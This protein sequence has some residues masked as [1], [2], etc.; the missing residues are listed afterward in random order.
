M[1]YS[2]LFSLLSFEIPHHHLT[3]R[4][5]FISAFTKLLLSEVTY[6][7]HT[8]DTGRRISFLQIVTLQSYMTALLCSDASASPLRAAPVWDQSVIY[9]Q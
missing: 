7:I 9:N 8:S 2:A 5:N 1:H 3:L 6:L 4:S